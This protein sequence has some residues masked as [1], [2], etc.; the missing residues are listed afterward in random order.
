M[1]EDLK[2]SVARGTRAKRILEDDMVVEA[3][4]AIEKEI[5]DGWKDSRAHDEKGRE[6]AYLLHRILGQFK[7]EFE[8]IVRDGDV[9][10]SVLDRLKQK[11][12][13][14]IRRVI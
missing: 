8:R 9:A 5:A 12:K 6:N 7:G 2:H 14:K 3:F 13:Q 1:T 4:A 10:K 11:A